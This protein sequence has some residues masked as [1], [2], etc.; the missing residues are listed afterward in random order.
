MGS[1]K[2]FWAVSPWGIHF[3]LAGIAVYTNLQLA[4]TWAKARGGCRRP[5]V[6]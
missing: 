5:E 6:R 1:N 4:K 3:F 2:G